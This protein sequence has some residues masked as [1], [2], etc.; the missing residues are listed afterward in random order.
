[1]SVIEAE[2]KRRRIMRN[3]NAYTSWR[4]IKNELIN[5]VYFRK[6][7]KTHFEVAFRGK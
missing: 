7:G 3:T 2:A 1:M 4:I 6:R 5:Q